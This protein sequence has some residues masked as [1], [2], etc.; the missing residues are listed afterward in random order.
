MSTILLAIV[1]GDR[2]D[3]F[4]DVLAGFKPHKHANKRV[5]V[6]LI[7]QESPRAQLTLEGIQ[8]QADFRSFNLDKLNI[9]PVS[10]KRLRFTPGELSSDQTTVIIDQ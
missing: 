6:H 2:P 3:D 10:L 8:H 9:G 4:V 5:S 1:L 7:V